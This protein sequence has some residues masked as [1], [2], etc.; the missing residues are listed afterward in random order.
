MNELEYLKIINKTLTDSSFIGDDCAFLPVE[1]LGCN[2]IYVTQDSL[3]QDIHFSLDTTTPYLL[4]R[5]AVSVNLSDL[6]AMCAKPLCITI[7]LS[8]PKAFDS[9]FIADFYKGVNEVCETYGVKVVGGDLT[10]SDKVFVSVCAIGSKFT[11]FNISRANAKKGDVV[12]TT[13]YHGDSAGGLSLLSSGQRESCVLIDAHLN[14]LP[15][16]DKS[17]LLSN[18]IQTDFAMMD[19]SDGLGDALFK[20]AQASNVNIECDFSSVPVSSEL[21]S[22]FPNTYK[23]LVLW[24]GEDY[25]LLFT[26]SE[27]VYE[28]LDDTIFFKIG[29]VVSTSEES[30]V[31][32]KDSECIIINEKTL[33]ENSYNHFGEKS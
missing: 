26:V 24:G 23:S 7:S 5:K 20:I 18:I 32:I 12:V 2:G 19:T 13:G 28:K 8:L 14:P 6:A 15:Q 4:G 3:V 29:Q 9:N 16:L 33:I 25:Q 21:K 17:R 10:G 11:P 22:K 31:L 27:E 30:T 1:I